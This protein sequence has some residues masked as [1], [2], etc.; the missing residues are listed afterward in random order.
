MNVG[1]LGIGFGDVQKLQRIERKVLMASS[2]LASN[3]RVA[4]G[5]VDNWKRF[6]TSGVSC[7]KSRLSIASYVADMYTHQQSLKFLQDLLNS[8]YK[9]VS[10]LLRL[11]TW[12]DL[13]LV[14]T[15]N[16]QCSCRSSASCHRIINPASRHPGQS[17]ARHTRRQSQLRHS[18][19]KYANWYQINEGP[20]H[21]RHGISSAISCCGI[22]I[23]VLFPSMI[24]TLR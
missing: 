11:G 4:E 20:H 2:A 13:G 1:N 16:R 14:L 21:N 8:T 15:R 7:Y 3:S 19:C 17:C 18:G 12:T 10:F 23:L 22:L 24:L 6:D 9:L 5:L